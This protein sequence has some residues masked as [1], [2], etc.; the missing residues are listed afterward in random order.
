MIAYPVVLGVGGA[1]YRSTVETLKNL[2]APRDQLQRALTE[3]HVYAVTI[4]HEAIKLKRVLEHQHCK[5]SRK[6]NGVG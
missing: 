6:R 5:H 1:I 4:L 2:G 3:L